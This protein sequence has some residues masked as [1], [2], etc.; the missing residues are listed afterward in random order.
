MKK[1]LMTV[2]DVD[3]EVLGMFKAKAAE[4]RMKMGKA[5]T[6]AMRIWIKAKG[7][8]KKSGKLFAKVKPFDWGKN[9]KR[10][11]SQVDDILYDSA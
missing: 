2:R 6:E 3:V 8:T 1:D 7:P 11:S 4:R 10:T 9:T 5:L